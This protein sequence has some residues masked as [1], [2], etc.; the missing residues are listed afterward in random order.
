LNKGQRDFSTAHTSLKGFHK[1]YAEVV[2]GNGHFLKLNPQQLARKCKVSDPVFEK[3]KA[4]GMLLEDASSVDL[5]Q[6]EKTKEEHVD[7]LTIR[8]MLS[9][10]KKDLIQCIGRYLE[11]WTPPNAD[12]NWAKK[13][14]LN[15]RPKLRL[16]KPKLPVKLTYFRKN[17]AR[18]NTRWQKI[19][20]PSPLLEVDL[21]PVQALQGSLA[22]RFLEKGKSSWAGSRLDSPSPSP[23]SRL[24]HRSSLDG[25]ISEG[26]LAEFQPRILLKGKSL[27]VSGFLHVRTPLDV[28]PGPPSRGLVFAA[29]PS[30]SPAGLLQDQASRE[31]ALGSA[32]ECDVAKLQPKILEKGESSL[33]SSSVSSRF[34]L[35]ASSDAT[36]GS[37]LSAGPLHVRNPL[38]VSMCL[39]SQSP[40]A[41][42]PV[43]AC[44][45]PYPPA[46][47]S[48]TLEGA[49]T[50]HQ[51]C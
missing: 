32:A 6:V 43:Y 40:P 51:E 21:G 3:S 23:A 45:K 7:I 22:V 33:V 42:G 9:D 16:E 19:A 27:L 30:P 17:K 18:P 25:P 48:H 50:I 14:A 20:R 29:S 12:V 37:P 38:E 46:S 41:G 36:S 15:G 35:N 34:C 5:E 39:L 47:S 31:T 13:G 26:V 4:R 2:Q 11:G 28:T 8:D 10:F 1:S 24:Q 49:L 44:E